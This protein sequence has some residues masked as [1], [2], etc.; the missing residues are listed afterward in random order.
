MKSEEIH[1]ARR[2]HGH[3]C[4]GLALGIRVAEAARREVG[5]HQPGAEVVAIVESDM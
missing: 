3:D 2:F 5:H 1:F 4:P